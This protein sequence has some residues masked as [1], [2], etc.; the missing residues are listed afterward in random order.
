MTSST[1]PPEGQHIRR[2]LTR[3]TLIASAGLTAARAAGMVAVG[4]PNVYTER[5][6]LSAAHVIVGSL[7]DVTSRLLA[8]L[9]AGRS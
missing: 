5:Q 3:R 9:A 4:V 7:R 1:P 6:D 2:P 8:R